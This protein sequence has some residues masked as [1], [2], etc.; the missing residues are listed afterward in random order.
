[1][2]TVQ[3]IYVHVHVYSMGQDTYSTCTLSR[4]YTVGRRTHTCTVGLED[5]HVH[6]PGYTCTCTCI[7]YGLGYI[8][9]MY[10]YTVQGIYSRAQNT[11]MYMYITCT[12]QDMYMYIVG[13]LQ[14]FIFASEYL[15]NRNPL[16]WLFYVYMCTMDM[17]SV[18]VIYIVHVHMYTVCTCLSIKIELTSTCLLMSV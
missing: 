9:Y 1:M 16:K 13:V 10:M 8:Q 7:Q 3:D 2:Y 14:T 17:Y 11:Y 18:H 4:A 12:L 5:I 15:G 6:C